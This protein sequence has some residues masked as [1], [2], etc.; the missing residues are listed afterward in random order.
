MLLIGAGR[1]GTAL[2]Q[3]AGPDASTLIDRDSGW[4]ALQGEVGEPIVL[5]VRN[6]D[7]DTVIERVPKRRHQDLV[8]VQNGAVR[9]YLADRGL[10]GITRG[11]LYFAVAKRGDPI[12]PGRTSWFSG[13]HALTCAAFLNRCGVDA[14]NVDWMRFTAKEFEKMAWILVFGPLCDKYQAPVGRI[15]DEHYDEVAALTAEIRVIGRR[16]MSVDLPIDWLV[17]RLCDYSRSI[18]DYRA[19]VK[20]WEWRNGWVVGVAEKAGIDLPVHSSILEAATAA[21][22][23]GDDV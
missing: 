4:D 16:A 2:H 1:I 19:A 9:D 6:D 22:N 7:L 11:L 8:V 3:A 5:C 15:V 14:Q 23:R 20:E 17:H 21:R 10:Q 12:S 13:P 18:P